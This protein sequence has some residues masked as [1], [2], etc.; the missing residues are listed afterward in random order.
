MAAMEREA[1][2]TEVVA[3][4]VQSVWL[5]SLSLVPAPLRV[6]HVCRSADRA[7][8]IWQL[9][10]HDEAHTARPGQR[11]RSRGRAC[12]GGNCI[13]IIRPRSQHGVYRRGLFGCMFKAITYFPCSKCLCPRVCMRR[14]TWDSPESVHCSE[15]LRTDRQSSRL[16]SDPTFTD[17]AYDQR[18]NS[19]LLTNG[20]RSPRMCDCVPVLTLIAA[21]LVGI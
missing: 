17:L 12:L 20:C 14:V 5:I 19:S 11:R 1:S 3:T 21:S 6:P 9:H 2:N 16:A 10:A 4:H 13:R 18:T 8:C 7:A 15:C